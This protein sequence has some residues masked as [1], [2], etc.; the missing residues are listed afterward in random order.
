MKR[1]SI[2]S[3]AIATAF[4]CSALLIAGCWGSDP[5]PAPEQEATEL[6]PKEEVT[7]DATQ[8]ELIKTAKR[9]YEARMFSVARQSLQSLR[10]NY[11]GG[12]YALFS[13]LKL[14]DCFYYNHEYTE[15]AAAYQEYYKNNPGTPDVAYAKLQA[16]RSFIHSN[17]GVGRDKGPLEKAL[18][19][20]D[21]LIADESGSPLIPE[22]K[23]ERTIAV[24]RLADQEKLIAEFYERQDK[25]EAVK[26]REAAFKER[27]A[28]LLAK[29]SPA[30]TKDRPMT[31]L[32][33]TTRASLAL[34]VPAVARVGR[35]G[36]AAPSRAGSAALSAGPAFAPT[37]QGT[38]FLQRVQCKRG[39]Y[40]FVSME[41]SKV[42]AEGVDLAFPPQDG[43]VVFRLR[44]LVTDGLVM[45]CFGDKDLTITPEG[46]VTIL[47][48]RPV[49]LTSLP[50]PPRLLLTVEDMEDGA[51]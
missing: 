39:D 8:D 49:R 35:N 19:I 28:P 3:R 29:S 23:A 17:R 46:V 14:A 41:V 33:S 26:A 13:E 51:G 11:P 6:K 1:D 22:A 15:A 37:G 18:G 27:W 2:L 24:Q 45:N 12:P 50:L 43:K 32:K 31:L 38:V 44:G 48:N 9:L 25:P 7:T 4:S 42:P 36:P 21:G 20:L 40:P 47:M 34:P 10:D 5:E 16:A 30:E